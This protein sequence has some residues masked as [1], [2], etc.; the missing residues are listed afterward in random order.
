MRRGLIIINAY[1]SLASSLNQSERLKAEFARLGVETDVRRNNFFPVSIAEGGEISSEADGYDFCVY[2]DKDKYVSMML[3]KRGMR[4]FNRHD[5]IE[6]CDDKMVTAVRLAGRGIPMPKTL[7]GLLCYD[8]G[9]HVPEELLDSVE[10]RLGYPVVMKTA[11]GSLGKGVFLLGSREELRAKAEE[12]MRTPHLYQQFISESRGRDLRIIVI[13]HRC[14]AAMLR[15]SA[16][17]FRS[18]LELGG[19]GTPYALP[20]KTAALC[21]EVSEVLGLDYC[22]VDLLFGEEGMLV[23]EVNSNAFFGGIERVTGVNVG[24]LYAEHICR[25][26]YHS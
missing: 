2:L 5:A 10:R 22:G 21:E 9:V 26:V 25:E 17:D 15:E 14:V 16:G 7:P 8:E 23:C 18:N 12:L 3:E 4:L 19:R 20:A 6:A 24:R 11:C 1:S 13:G